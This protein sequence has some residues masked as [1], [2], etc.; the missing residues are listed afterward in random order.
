MFRRYAIYHLPPAGTEWSRFATRWLGWDAE[1]GAMAEPLPN[2][3]AGEI[4]ETPR[5]Y[6]LHATLKPPFHLAQGTTPEGL[7]QATADLAATLSPV[8][9]DGLD[10]ARIGR[11][12]ALRPRGD[13]TALNALAAAC[14]RT[15]DAFR[16]PPD[17][18]ELARRRARRLSEQQEANLARW[19]YP[20][21]M[22]L[23]RFHIT[24]SGSLDPETLA[25]T[26]ARLSQDLAPLLPAP[27]MI[28]EIA[29]VG[30]MDDTRF[31]LISRHQLTGNAA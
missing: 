22:D 20:H 14:V 12:L 17:E 28:D 13:E 3:P 5:R 31:R 16:A 18:A 2:P 1:T 15:L 9:L 8:R 25:A 27:Y 21:V 6:G 19:G 10:L 11:F 30:E 7:A 4:V 29:L 26:E 24:L 23:F